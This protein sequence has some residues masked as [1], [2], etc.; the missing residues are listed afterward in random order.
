[1]FQSSL[2]KAERFMV[3]IVQRRMVDNS[4]AALG[5]QPPTTQAACT[6]LNPRR[7]S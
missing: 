5:G 2:G 1:M 7:E 4:Q 3:L 6:S